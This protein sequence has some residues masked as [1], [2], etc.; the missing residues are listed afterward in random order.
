M[1]KLLIL[2]LGFL[3]YIPLT[4][5]TNIE[6]GSSNNSNSTISEF[7]TLQ[8]STDGLAELGVNQ[9]IFDEFLK[10]VANQLKILIDFSLK[11]QVNTDNSLTLESK[12]KLLNNGFV[13]YAS[14]TEHKLIVNVQFANSSFRDYFCGDDAYSNVVLEEKFFVINRVVTM[15]PSVVK[16][17]INE[18]IISLPEAVYNYVNN[19]ALNEFGTSA[20]KVF[21]NPQYEYSLITSLH[22]IHSNA[23]YISYDNG[24][25]Y[26]T[27]IVGNVDD[28][29]IKTYTTHANTIIWYLSAVV[30]TLIFALILWGV[31]LLKNKKLKNIN[32]S[33]NSQ[34]IQKINNEIKISI[35]LV[36]SDKDS[37]DKNNK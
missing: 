9:E 31:S 1:K 16:I 37:K 11:N 33:N 18:D 5:F 24:Y 32:I 28:L 12:Q 6:Y 26:H 22:R 25:Y 17:N 34:N 20:L 3:I 10:N 15:K 4:G 21:Q 14:V 7:V 36:E 19:M 27:W 35:D 30:L 2:L 29:I 13:V 8:Q 23:S